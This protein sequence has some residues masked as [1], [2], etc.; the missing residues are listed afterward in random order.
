MRTAAEI[1]RFRGQQDLRPRGYLPPYSPDFNSIEN[2]FSKLKAYLR[3]A[4][5]RT[6][7]RAVGGHP[8]RTGHL[9]PAGLRQLLRRRW[10]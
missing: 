1:D 10:I 8:R 6:H 7:R 5:A 9:Y 3:K 2:A 4:A